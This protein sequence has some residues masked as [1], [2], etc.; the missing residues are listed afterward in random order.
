[1]NK[2]IPD[3]FPVLKLRLD[4]NIYGMNSD[5]M[6]DFFIGVLQKQKLI[7]PNEDLLLSGVSG[8]KR[9]LI[10]RTHAQRTHTYAVPISFLQHHVDKGNLLSEEDPFRY[11]DTSSVKAPTVMVYN[12]EY[13]EKVH[14]Y[15]Y[16]LNS[17]SLDVA[18]NLDIAT[19]AAVLLRPSTATTATSTN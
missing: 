15:Y 13:L 7:L 8:T 19:R 6:L 18:T 14:S 1:M 16:G 4:L 2:H 5:S 10:D 9:L 17:S 11:A 3:G 12:P